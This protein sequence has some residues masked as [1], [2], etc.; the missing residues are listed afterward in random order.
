MTNRSM[1]LGLAEIDVALRARWWVCRVPADSNP[2]DGPSRPGWCGTTLGHE[3]VR[4][5][6]VWPRFLT[7]GLKGVRSCFA[8]PRKGA[9]LRV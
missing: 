2:A 5:E 9:R 4:D 8:N 6:L 3:A 7:E 1:L